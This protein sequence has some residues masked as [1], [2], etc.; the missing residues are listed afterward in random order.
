[1]L[2]TAKLFLAIKQM[3]RLAERGIWRISGVR[4]ISARLCNSQANVQDQAD[5]SDLGPSKILEDR[6]EVK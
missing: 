3:E 6:D 1:M 2:G 5:I 4:S